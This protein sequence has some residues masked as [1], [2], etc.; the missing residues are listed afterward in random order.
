MVNKQCIQRPGQRFAATEWTAEHWHCYSVASFPKTPSDVGQSENRQTAA[1]KLECPVTL[2]PASI[3]HFLSTLFHATDNEL[4]PKMEDQISHPYV[5]FDQVTSH[6]VQMVIP[7]YLL[8]HW[9]SRIPVLLNLCNAVYAV[10]RFSAVK[11]KISLNKNLT[12][13]YH[14]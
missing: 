2:S 11:N 10:P 1:I 14:F 3:K 13:V 7:S 12:A 4:S 5:A 8:S 6:H 9:K